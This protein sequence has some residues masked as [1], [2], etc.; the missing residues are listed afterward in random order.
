VPE[1]IVGAHLRACIQ[2]KRQ[3]LGQEQ[4]LHGARF[5]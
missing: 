2:R 3:N 1:Y 4:N 5:K